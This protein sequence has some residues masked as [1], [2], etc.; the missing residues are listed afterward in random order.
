MMPARSVL[1]VILSLW[2]FGAGAKGNDWKQAEALLRKDGVEGKVYP[3]K[4]LPYTFM[5]RE[6]TNNIYRV[7]HHGKLLPRDGLDTLVAYLREI[8]AFKIGELERGDVL[9]L[10]ESFKALPQATGPNYMSSGE[11]GPKLERSDNELKLVL[12]YFVPD[13]SKYRPGVTRPGPGPTQDVEKF[14]LVIDRS[15]PAQWTKEVI[16]VDR[17]KTY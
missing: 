8:D 17:N 14:T 9:E 2:P 16:Q 5:V 12:H 1:I 3:Q 13:D 15:H 11:L 7:V 10:L 6:G 4:H